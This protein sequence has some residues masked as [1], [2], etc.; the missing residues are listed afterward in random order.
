MELPNLRVYEIF[1]D[2]TKYFTEKLFIQANATLTKMVN[3][4]Y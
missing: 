2:P 4:L 1:K 3:I